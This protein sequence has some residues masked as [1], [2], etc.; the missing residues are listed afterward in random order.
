LIATYS[1]D[2]QSR[3]VK[4][5][6]TSLA[7][8]GVTE[9][10][11]LYDGWNRIATFST[12]NSTFSIQNCT[13]FGRDLSGTLEGAGG[14]GGLLGTRDAQL[15]T[16]Y[17]F[18]YD[19]NGNVSES[20]E[21][22]G[23]ISAHY[24]YDPFGNLAVVSGYYAASNPWRFSTKPVDAETGYSY[25]GYRLYTPVLGRW[26]NRDPIEEQGGLNLYGF[27]GNR[28]LDLADSNGRQINWPKIPSVLDMTPP[29]TPI[30][31]PPT[32]IVPP[33]PPA[34]DL[35]LK[36]ER[37]VTCIYTCNL[38]SWDNSTCYYNCPYKSGP[39]DICGSSAPASPEITEG[40]VDGCDNSFE[41]VDLVTIIQ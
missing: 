4:K 5:I 20:I 37:K 26:V 13:T 35:R 11:Y 1:Y 9:E 28:S 36:R 38:Q 15:T 18:T 41:L 2:G 40:C 10:V 39:L 17:V 14:V 19:A 6:T 29:P 23:S 25:Y 7:P 27:V 8:Q 3:R 31:T 33:N 16:S 32:S 21:G 30:P 22:S 12:Q 34:L 24:E